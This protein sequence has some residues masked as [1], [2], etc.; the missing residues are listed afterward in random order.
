MPQLIMTLAAIGV[1]LAGG[2]IVYGALKKTLASA[3]IRRNTTAPT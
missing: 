3:S 1:A 2:T